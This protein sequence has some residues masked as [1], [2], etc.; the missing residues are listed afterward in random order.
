MSLMQ[1]KIRTV[2][3]RIQRSMKT[4]YPEYEETFSDMVWKRFDFDMVVG[5]LLN[6][7]KSFPY[8][9]MVLTSAL[10]AW[11]VA[12]DRPEERRSAIITNVRL[13]LAKEEKHVI[14][15]S[16]K[17]QLYFDAVYRMIGVGP[18]FM[19]DIYYPIGGIKTLVKERGD[20]N[21]RNYFGDK[22][23]NRINSF[24]KVLQILHHE[25]QNPRDLGEFQPGSLT[26]VYH[27]I[28]AINK[29]IKDTKM[30]SETTKKYSKQK[31]LE[32]LISKCGFTLVLSY[33]ASL[34]QISEGKTLLDR[35]LS[36]YVQFTSI[37]RVDAIERWLGISAYL[38]EEVISKLD[39]SKLYHGGKYDVLKVMP[40]EVECAPLELWEK[41]IIEE[42]MKK[43]YH[44][45]PK[46]K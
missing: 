29:H 15:A 30:L 28:E 23:Q 34:V 25:Y 16:E 36:P 2:E 45:Q 44:S 37:K 27:S 9:K 26:R 18:R 31:T 17:E 46:N 42:K 1:N 40:I 13:A 11:V 6:R 19:R 10:G 7:Q 32:N 21:N 4:N 38:F 14:S 5:I 33:A 24:G 41:K 22:F 39:G 43:S 20:G 12:T 8:H 35:F 3:E